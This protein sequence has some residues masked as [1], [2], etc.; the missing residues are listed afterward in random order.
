MCPNTRDV[1]KKNVRT[2]TTFPMRC[3]SASVSEQWR[4]SIVENGQNETCCSPGEIQ[5][6][7]LHFGEA[8]L[9]LLVSI[10]FY[11]GL[12]LACVGAVVVVNRSDCQLQGGQ[13]R[14]GTNDVDDIRLQL[15]CN[16]HFKHVSMTG[17]DLAGVQS[18]GEL[19]MPQLRTLEH[20]T[21]QWKYYILY[22]NLYFNHFRVF[23]WGG[24]RVS[25][26]KLAVLRNT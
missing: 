14:H 21:V 19:K 6:D 23:K 24:K 2:F 22:F 12:K 18:W 25:L 9:R 17:Y 15:H 7:L 4:N 13:V 5:L 8:H 20:F 11:L 26:L 1:I 10:L 16:Y 3:N